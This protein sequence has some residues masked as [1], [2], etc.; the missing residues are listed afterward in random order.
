MKKI[1]DQVMEIVKIAQDCPENLQQTCFEVL[2]THALGGGKAPTAEPTPATGAEPEKK[3]PISIVEKSAQTQDDIAL[4]D[5]HVKMRRFMEKHDLSVDHL[6]QLFYKEGDQILPL[7]EDL[8]TTRTSESQVRIALLRCLH[9]AILSGEFQTTVE[10]TRQEAITRKCYAKNNWGNNF[11][12]NAAFFDFN[13]Y[14]K[15][16]TAIALSE[17]GKKKLADIIKDLQ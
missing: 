10:D 15:G 4:T 13:K 2:L 17:Q 16:L 9:N 8:K 7:Y 3:E 6:N 12:N 1:R 5:V 11:T 14:A